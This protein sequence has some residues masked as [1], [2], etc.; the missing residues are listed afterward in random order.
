[1]N[2]LQNP[3]TTG[4]TQWLGPGFTAN[5]V[6]ALAFKKAIF[7]GNTSVDTKYYQ[8][9]TAQPVLFREYMSSQAV[10]ATPPT[11]FVAMGTADI[12]AEFKIHASELGAFQTTITGSPSFSISK[13]T[14]YPYIFKI[15]NC[16]MQPYMSNPMSSFSGFTG[17]T[18]VNLLQNVIPFIFSGGAYNGA[19][20]RTVHDTGA[21]S[22]GGRDI[23]LPQQLAYVFDY[24]TGIF[25]CYANDTSPGLPNP[26]TK[27]APPAVTCYVYRGT[28][29]QFAGDVWT[30]T[31]TTV[32]L[33]GRTIVLGKTTTNDPSLIMDISGVS[34]FKNLVTESL[35]TRSDRRFKENIVTYRPLEKILDL[36]PKTYNYIGGST[37][38]LG[39][40]AQ[41]VEEVVPELVTTH[42]GMKSLQY[43]RVGV[44]LLP[45]VKEQSERIRR[46]EKELSDMKDII[47]MMFVKKAVS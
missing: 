4:S 6:G 35:S 37:K 32:G 41:D 30:V 9:P 31:P 40:I 23:V 3:M 7:R 18:K 39:L 38:E 43:D 28:F 8:E 15:T 16:L 47:K 19:F 34:F 36:Q 26:I 25:T 20:R 11:D 29:G 13:S 27:D 2:A 21:L 45:I 24:D 12:A 42:K 10:P 22:A 14:A 5:N 46:L 44:L 1:M 17:K 33:I